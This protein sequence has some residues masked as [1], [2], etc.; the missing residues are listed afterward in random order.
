MAKEKKQAFKIFLCFWDN[1]RSLVRNTGS[2]YAVTAALGAGYYPARGPN[3]LNT[4]DWAKLSCTLLAAVGRGYKLQYSG[5]MD[6]V[7]DRER[8]KT[9]DPSPVIPKALTYFHR[10]STTIE[11]LG[12]EVDADLEDTADLQDSFKPPPRVQREGNQGSI[13]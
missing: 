7:L 10:L 2:G 13:H 11:Q 4:E 5:N 3:L 9:L 12:V 6:T 1:S 8:K